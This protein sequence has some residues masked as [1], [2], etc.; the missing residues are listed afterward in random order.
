MEQWDDLGVFYFLLR[1][2]L[3]IEHKKGAINSLDK[4][5][6]HLHMV[7]Y[8][9]TFH[10]NHKQRIIQ[11]VVM[12]MFNLW[13]IR[14]ARYIGINDKFSF[15]RN[16][17]YMCS[18][19]TTSCPAKPAERLWFGKGMALRE[20]KREDWRRHYEET[21]RSKYFSLNIAMKGLH[22]GHLDRFHIFESEML[23]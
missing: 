14:S 3:F 21:K 11:Q 17:R 6:P 4:P 16:G 7:Q 2:Q 13:W 20:T 19:S 18:T 15:R 9:H 23:L 1:V 12:P 5:C 8:S 10:Y 22:T